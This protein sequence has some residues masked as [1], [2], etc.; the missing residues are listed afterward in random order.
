MKK[1]KGTPAV[2]LASPDDVFDGAT[3]RRE[4][5]SEVEAVI[6]DTAISRRRF[7][8]GSMLR[9]GE[10]AEWTLPRG[11][12][13]RTPSSWG[14]SGSFWVREEEAR[15]DILKALGV[16]LSRSETYRKHL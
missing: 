1:T 16:D 9:S 8:V 2:T 5:E 7:V 13:F 12:A 10:G 4:F 15:A 11:K 3:V 6:D 14:R